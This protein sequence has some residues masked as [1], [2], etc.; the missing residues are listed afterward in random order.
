MKSKQRIRPPEY[1]FYT[2]SG[3]SL[4]KARAPVTGI[5]IATLQDA[6]FWMQEL[7]QRD[8]IAKR[9]PPVLCTLPTLLT[10]HKPYV[11]RFCFKRGPTSGMM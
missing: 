11:T 4:F 6:L 5:N 10:A 1:A 8:G 9:P 3:G 2:K 7:T